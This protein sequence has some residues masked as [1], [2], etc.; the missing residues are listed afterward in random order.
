MHILQKF[1]DFS[2]P[3]Q[4]I[5]HCSPICVLKLLWASHVGG[6]C[7]LSSTHTLGSG[8]GG[9]N[10]ESV[11]TSVDPDEFTHCCF[12]AGRCQLPG[13][14]YTNPVIPALK[15]SVQ[16]SCS[17]VSDS[18]RPHGLQHARLPC[19]SPTP[20]VYS[21]SCPLSQWCH[22]TISSSVMPFSSCPQSFPASGSFQVR[23]LQNTGQSGHLHRG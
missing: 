11:T 4:W 8:C 18:L 19:P 3:T 22:P 9:F 6:M 1:Y 2:F 14:I 12:R 23:N 20:G 17:V 5:G 10:R 21:N 15:P 13:A 7:M 16:F